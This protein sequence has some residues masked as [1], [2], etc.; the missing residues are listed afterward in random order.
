MVSK[1]SK[2]KLFLIFPSLT[3]A[4]GDPKS[5]HPQFTVARQWRKQKDQIETA[6]ASKCHIVKRKYTKYGKGV[7]LPYIQQVVIYIEW[8][9]PVYKNIYNLGCTPLQ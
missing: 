7:L 3:Y 8:N 1:M 6:A 9:I 2:I 5:I 4:N